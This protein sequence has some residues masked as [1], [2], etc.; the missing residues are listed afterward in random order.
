MDP[1]SLRRFLRARHRFDRLVSDP[2]PRLCRPPRG[3]G[4]RA[5]IP[6]DEGKIR[7]VGVSN[8]TPV[9]SRPAGTPAVPAATH[10]PEFRVGDTWRCGWGAD[11][12]M[13]TG[14]TPLAWSPLGGSVIGMTIDAAEEQ[15]S[16]DLAGLLKRLDATASA[17]GV[18]RA[19]V[20]LAW[21]LAHQRAWLHHRHATS[22]TDSGQP[23]SL[24]VS[25]DRATWNKFSRPPRASPPV[26]HGNPMNVR[27]PFSFPN[28]A[29]WTANRFHGA[30]PF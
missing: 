3:T 15:L 16:S 14:V 6:R 24:D 8:Y 12:Y 7:A 13:E 4:I 23:R 19:A 29:R 17:Q 11:Q 22:R 27:S 9:N 21:V 25:L 26:S 18:S 20:A 1:T 5:D 10:Q 2:S 30:Q 28:N